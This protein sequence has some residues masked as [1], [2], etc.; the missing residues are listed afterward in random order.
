[1]FDYPRRIYQG[2]TN[3][4]FNWRN[5]VTS[6]GL[7]KYLKKIDIFIIPHT[8]IN[9]IKPHQ[10]PLTDSWLQAFKLENGIYGMVTKIQEHILQ[11]HAT[12]PLAY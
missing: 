11:N 7:Q 2:L 3:E 5:L 8:H 12:R 10:Q 4:Q 1:M 9:C 6:R